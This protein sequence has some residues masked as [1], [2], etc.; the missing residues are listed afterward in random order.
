MLFVSSDP[1]YKKTIT[2]NVINHA[3]II[4]LQCRLA[5]P[6][7]QPSKRANFFIF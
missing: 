1:E 6:T 5:Q 7:V 4:D 2:L 3:M